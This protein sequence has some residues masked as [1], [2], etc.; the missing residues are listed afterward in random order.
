MTN[1]EPVNILVV[2]DQ[3]SK[4]LS[5]EAILGNSGEHI[6]KAMSAREAFEHLLKNDVALMLIDVVMP[7]L[8]GFELASMIREHPRFRKIAVIFV[9]ALALTDPDRI[10]GYEYGAVDY[11][12]VPVV[13]EVLRAKVRIFTDL[14]RKTREL[15][16]LNA[17]LEQR[18]E[19]RT[20]ELA[21]ANAE[22]ERRV[23]QRTREREMALAQVHEMQK[24]ESLG[25]L[26]GG[27]AHDF[28][29]VLMAILGNLEFVER[30]ITDSKLK[31]MVEA[32]SRAAWRGAKL[33]QQLLAYARKQRLTPEAVNL[34]RLLG[35]EQ[36][37]M[38]RR[39]LGGTVEVKTAFREDLWAA[40]VDPAQIELVVLNLAINARDA[41]PDG[42][43]ITIETRNVRVPDDDAM[44][45]LD[46]GEYVMVAVADTGTGMSEEV[47]AKC[48]EPFF[49]TKE[50]GKG[51]GLGLSQVYGLAQQSGGGVSLQTRPGHGTRIAVYLPRTDKPVIAA[52]P[53]HQPVAGDYYGTILVVEDQQDV[54]ETTVENLS[55]LG[56]SAVPAASGKDALALI[57][58]GKSFDLVLTDFAMPAMSGLEFA[59][60]VQ[61]KTADLPVIIVT[62]YAGVDSISPPDEFIILR[63]PYK[64]DQLATAIERARARPT[65]RPAIS[66]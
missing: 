54:R 10:K 7:D 2:D 6:L 42:G 3:P 23:E 4:L 31:R 24:L 66:A 58:G 49:S 19:E 27:V 48:F 28:N 12:P 46:P 56:Y 34:N 15:E 50:P 22:L 38:L 52:V 11:V 35:A 13:P 59:R 1:Q 63:K 37:D 45:E 14:Y 57:E 32:A 53:G 33:T 8:D 29:N 41:M 43:T 60:A 21:Q 47:A 65:L 5:Y 25:Q 55:A 40:L 36:V 16:R 17:D 30:R 51:S 9:S 20:A 18:V 62:G 64:L 61:G 39:T 44:S 26:T